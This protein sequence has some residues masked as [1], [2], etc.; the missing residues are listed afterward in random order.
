MTYDGKKLE[1][2]E[3]AFLVIVYGTCVVSAGLT[4]WFLF[5][6]LAELV[7]P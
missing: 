7:T 6:V 3:V 1:P 2:S 5:G 4:F